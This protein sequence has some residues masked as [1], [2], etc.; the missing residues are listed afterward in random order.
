M[1][2][3]A[4]RARELIRTGYTPIPLRG[5]IPQVVGWQK[6]RNVSEQD[7]AA[8]E[9]KGWFENIGLVCGSASN[10]L[11]VIDFDG[12]EG[13][14][15][16]KTAFPELADTFTVATGS[17]NGMHVY[18]KCELLNSSRKV[19]DIPLDTGELINIE[20]KADGSQVVIPPS[21]HPDTK[22]PYVRA[23]ERPIRTVSD[24]EAVWVW[25]QSF[26]P[27]ENWQPPVTYTTDKNL[28]PALLR[29]LQSRLEGQ[30]FKRHGD[31]INTSCPNSAAHRHGDKVFSFGFNTVD[32]GANCYR[33]GGMSLKKLCEYLN[34]DAKDYGGIY[35]YQTAQAA[36]PMRPAGSPYAQPVAAIAP[37]TV[38][39]RSSRLTTYVNRMLD[40]DAP[41]ENPPVPNPIKA[42]HKFGG[43]ARVLK[44]AKLFGVI[45]V[46]GGGKT[47]FLEALVDGWLPYH[48]SC[49]VW[50]PEWTPD[51][52]IERA[53]Q[54]YGGAPTDEL[55]L[56]EIFKYE[57]QNDV[58]N[59][60]GVE[61]SQDKQKASI[62]AIK[63][64][65][66][67]QEEVGYID[68]PFLNIGT[69]QS[70]IEAT[71]QSLTFRPRVLVIDYI[72]LF[73]A[74]ETD[75]NLT[76]Y[77]LLMK[78]KAVCAAHHLVG[79]IASQVTKDSARGQQNGAVLDGLAARYVNDD[80][81]NLFVT[82][83]PDRDE[84]GNFLPSTV[85]NVAKNSLGQRGR[86]RVATNWEQR[87]F[88]MHAHANQNFGE[89]D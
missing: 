57:L 43:M 32:G 64:L 33:C 28:N 10:N 9:T 26:K 37:L 78:L 12:L 49:L 54:R 83:N 77:N 17:G 36:A 60:A 2:I 73:Y 70:S 62:E 11:T 8:W 22:E 34:I 27:G 31:W 3:Y 47:S 86:V 29:E 53:V 18:L 15:L 87:S 4:E 89:D 40:F 44:A 85:L 65:R 51:E 52:F 42:L 1:N 81:F 41:V 63:M 21:I 58:K 13:Y 7:I 72:Q 50:S 69:L 38:V 30:G 48:V 67:W 46:S 68:A 82:V 59:G 23:I 55:Y 80:A 71:L 56:H 61:L 35:E 25:A 66:G 19:M 6:L 39:T 16:F 14:N 24:L 74:M 88:D 20:F 5:K 79:V 76:M 45:G 75:G 84:Q